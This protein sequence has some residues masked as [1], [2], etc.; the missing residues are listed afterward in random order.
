MQEA[1]Q[2]R[3]GPTIC[4]L[5]RKWSEKEIELL[6]DILLWTHVNTIAGWTAKTFNLHLYANTGVI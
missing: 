3:N 1:T 6:S 4:L 2:N 5:S